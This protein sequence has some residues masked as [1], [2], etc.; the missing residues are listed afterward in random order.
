MRSFN[1][2][3]IKKSVVRVI[4]NESCRAVY[5]SMDRDITLSSGHNCSELIL[6]GTL[7]TT[8]NG[9]QSFSLDLRNSSIG[10]DYT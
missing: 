6:S 1:F 9:F 7:D 4:L 2:L 3:T 5:G 10:V 8:L